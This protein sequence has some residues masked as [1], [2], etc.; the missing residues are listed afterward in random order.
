MSLC[1]SEM[2]GDNAEVLALLFSQEKKNKNI[3]VYVYIILKTEF[4]RIFFLERV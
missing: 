4:N 3:Y 2:E 1:G